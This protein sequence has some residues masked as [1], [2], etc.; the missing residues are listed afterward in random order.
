MT[1][2]KRGSYSVDDKVCTICSRDLTT[3]NTRASDIAQ[4]TYI[5]KICRQHRDKAKYIDR[6]EIIRE[7]QRIYDYSNKIKVM[8]A[9]GNKCICCNETTIEF[10]TID[11]INN[12][13]AN[14]KKIS[15]GKLY[16]W[17]IKNNFPKDNYQLLCYNCNCAKSFLGY[18][19]HNKP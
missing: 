12:N 9:Y 6:K 2:R 4:G 7:Q 5:C 16:R 14:N 10:L 11:Y 15:G 18:C 13:S 1:K 17:L 8:E 3:D 19:P